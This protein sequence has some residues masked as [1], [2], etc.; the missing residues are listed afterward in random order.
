MKTPQLQQITYLF[1]NATAA[2]RAFFDAVAHL[3]AQAS[4][5]DWETER[6]SFTVGKSISAEPALLLLSL[7][8]GPKRASRAAGG[9]YPPER[10]QSGEETTN[11]D[12][13]LS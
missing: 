4:G 3:L 13:T 12:I 2:S 8:L 11:F 1:P 10:R 6:G 9:S 5:A 7:H